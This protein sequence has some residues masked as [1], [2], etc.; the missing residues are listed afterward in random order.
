MPH[1]SQN[2][3]AKQKKAKPVA[4]GKDAGKTNPVKGSLV[5]C[6]VKLESGEWISPSSCQTFYIDEDAKFPDITYEI[7]TDAPPPYDWS[8]EIKWI[9]QACPQK[10]GKKRFKSKHSKTFSKKG[11][12]QSN[13][14]KWKADLGEVIGGELTVTVKAGNSK[15][16]RKT[17]IRGKNPS[18]EK[19]FAEI[20][21]YS[22]KN[23]A[24]LLKKIY[25]QE[26]HYRQFYSDEMPLVSFD[27]GYGMGQLTN[28]EPTY[29]QAWNW[30]ATTKQIMEKRLPQCREIAKKYLDQHPGYTDDMLDLETLVPY[31][32]MAKKQR[33]HNWDP[34]AKKW[35]VNDNVL[36]DPDQSNKGWLTTEKD[37]KDQTLT[38]LKTS[39][40]AKPF[41]TGRCYA[42]H[43][44]NAQ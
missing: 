27:N 25:K 7:K 34:T 37:N 19:I 28:P 17:L 20:D 38:E 14:K 16:I 6:E 42:E 22:D 4:K 24:G 15:F 29:E 5:I 40:K 32:G 12:F 35:I 30:K 18:Q 33:Y 31:N 43:I 21:A 26:S 2:H 3:P 13:D 36:C 23:N 8:W 9:V 39:K 41:Y 1:K 44:K 10:A 11:T